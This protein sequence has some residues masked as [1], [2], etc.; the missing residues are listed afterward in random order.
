VKLSDIDHV[1]DIIPGATRRTIYL[2]RGRGYGPRGVR[3]GRKLYYR[4]SDVLNFIAE[5]YGE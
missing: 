4:R 2:W 1:A 3:L 5:A